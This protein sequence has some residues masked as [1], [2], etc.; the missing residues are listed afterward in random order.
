[1]ALFCRLPAIACAGLAAAS[2]GQP[3]AQRE[4]RL[5]DLLK[6]AGRYVHEYEQSFSAVLSRE[7]Y[8]QRARVEGRLDT[9]DLRSEVALVALDDAAWVLF[10]DVHEVDGNALADRGD[11]L[12]ALFMKPTSNLGLQAKRIVD[13]GAR[14]N[15]G[16]I[17]RTLNTPT[18]ALDFIRVEN[19]S[20][21]V[22]RL[23]DARAIEGLE[24]LELWFEETAT[25]RMIV[26]KDNAAAAGRFWVVPET[27]TIVRT[28]LRISSL[29][30]AGV[31]TTS[32]ARQEELSL[33]VPTHMRESYEAQGSQT[34][35][36][37][38]VELTGKS[39][40]STT[41]LEGDATYTDFKR[42]S[43]NTKIII[44]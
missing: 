38:D 14:Y 16:P 27:G 7:H 5:A 34:T 23:G 12:A 9:R 6:S 3:T 17:T 39:R 22:F 37:L 4:D 28:E 44:R 20:R 35:G 31:L 29:G 24:T 15:L 13:E 21:S 25:P 33:W 32:Y 26:T 18:Q 43:V 11:R 1:M 2:A 19:Q 41:V 42:F 30:V 10:R 40:G 36:A 8:V